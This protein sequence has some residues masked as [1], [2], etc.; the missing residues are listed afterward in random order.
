MFNKNEWLE[1]AKT[2]K[3]NNPM[4]QD[5]RNSNIQEESVDEG[6]KWKAL[7]GFLNPK[8]IDLDPDSPTFNQKRWKPGLTNAVKSTTSAAT[9]GYVWAKSQD[10]QVERSRPRYWKS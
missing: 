5:F 9:Q 4:M 2:A 3:Q 7:K 10:R 8:E 6:K 1:W